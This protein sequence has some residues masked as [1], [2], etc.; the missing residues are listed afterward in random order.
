MTCAFL[1]LVGPAEKHLE[2]LKEVIDGLVTYEPERLDH[3]DVY[4][5]NDGNPGLEALIQT[6]PP[7]RNVTVF[8]NPGHGLFT[9]YRDRNAAG[10]FEGLRRVASEGDY[11]FMLKWIPTLS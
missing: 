6:F 8:R 10:I 1:A 11:D 9:Y 4:L 5:A 3:F 2:G 7:F